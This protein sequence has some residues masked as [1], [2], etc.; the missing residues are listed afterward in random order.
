MVYFGF[1]EESVTLVSPR[2]SSLSSA[3][4]AFCPVRSA[5]MVIEPAA[6]VAVVG[7]AVAFHDRTT[8]DADSVTVTVD[9]GLAVLLPHAATVMLPV[10]PNDGTARRFVI[11]DCDDYDRS[12]V[13]CAP[14]MCT[15]SV[16]SNRWCTAIG[17]Q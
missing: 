4:F 9:G 5:G 2:A 15:S 8:L 14:S 13:W 10:T 7:G 12:R 3:I 11:E 6:A 16:L 1:A 17:K